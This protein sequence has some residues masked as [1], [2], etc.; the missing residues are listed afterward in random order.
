M[1]RATP[2]S[3]APGECKTTVTI[4]N[5]STLPKSFTIKTEVPKSWKISPTEM[6]IKDM[7]GSKVETREFT[8]TW[9]TGWNKD[10]K[11]RI[12]LQ[13]PDGRVIAETSIIPPAMALAEI[14]KPIQ[15]NG[16]LKNWPAESKLPN[17]LL[18]ATDPNPNTDVY[19]GYSK[20]GIYMAVNVKESTV[21]E[22]DP[23]AFWAQDCIEIFIDSAYDRKE[24]NEYKETD[25]QFWVSPQ[26]MK[27][28]VYAGRWKR[29]SEIPAI[30]Y[31]MKEVKG[32]SKKTETGYMM[33][34]LIPASLIKGFKAEKGTK[35][36]LNFNISVTHAKRDKFEVFWATEKADKTTGKP[37]IWGSVEL[38]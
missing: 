5:N 8:V 6:E 35:I 32:F 28:G 11:A 20:D 37:Y 9:N 22:N 15:F 10:E 27:N 19:A 38:K 7:A 25:H 30:M 3:G 23:R 34:F 36:G 33:E 1:L 13:L 12:Y 16:D 14:T 26:T 18:G 4:G 24:R 17:W 31:D 2:L 29:N 21:A